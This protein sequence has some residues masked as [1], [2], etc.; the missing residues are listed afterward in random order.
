MKHLISVIFCLLVPIAASA[1]GIQFFQGSFDEALSLATKENKLLFVDVMTEWCG[2]C[3]NMESNVFPQQEVRDFYNQHFIAFQLDAEDSDLNGPEISEKYQVN[4]YPT[5]LFIQPDG[6][7]KHKA[8]GGMEAEAFITVGKQALGLDVL[9][10]LY[11]LQE[12][13][14]AGNREPKAVRAYLKEWTKVVPALSNVLPQEKSQELYKKWSNA[15]KDY[16]S[17]RT[18]Y[19]LTNAEDF[20]IITDMSVQFTLELSRGHPMV[21]YLINH[22]NQASSVIPEKSLGE[23]L[24]NMNYFGIRNAASK[25]DKETYQ[26]YVKDITGTLEQAYTFNDWTDVN[27]PAL[28]GAM[29]DMEYAFSRKD[30]PD[31]L[32]K[33]WKYIELCE[34]HTGA[35]ELLSFA[36]RLERAEGG[37]AYLPETLKFIQKAYDEYHNIYVPADYGRVLAK[38]GQPEKAREYYA[39][40][41][42]LADEMGGERGQGIRERFTKEMKELGL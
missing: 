42:K 6:T 39:E 24:M 25:G 10:V 12:K 27:P 36:R 34:S 28:L 41:M 3:K 33:G 29:G 2:P 22:Y 8:S 40:V 4:G 7:L 38:I 15:L 17:H 5:Y 1:N 37:S 9:S 23:F 19:E 26:R 35:S 21:E 30:Y 18:P 20:Q 16:F 31:Y 32:K 13:Y 14:D 11:G